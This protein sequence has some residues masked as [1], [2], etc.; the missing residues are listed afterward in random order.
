M[1]QLIKRFLVS[2]V[3][4]VTSICSVVAGPV[5]SA[6]AAASVNARAAIAIDAKSGQVLYSKNADSR[7]A[8]ASMS[9]LLTVAVI[10]HEIANG[11]LKWSTKVKIT[12]A[13][14]KLST[15]SG[16]S[17]VP[18]QSGHRYS[19]KQL[20]K[21]ALIKSGDAATIA[22]SRSRGQSTK[23]FVKEMGATAK[24][25][26]LK[27]YRLYNGVGLSNQDMASFK[28]PN[29][30][31]SAENEMTA[32]D[33]A[34]LA[35]YLIRNHP[36]LLK[37]TKQ[38]TLKWDGQT[39]QNGNELL[40]GNTQAPQKVTVD[41]LKTGTSDKAGQCFAST[42]TYRGHR[43][44]T[45]VMHASG[46]RFTQTKALYEQVFSNWRAHT[47]YQGATVAV[48]HGRQKKVRVRT[49]QKV[50]IWQPVQRTVTSKFVASPHY[51][52]KQGLKAPL[53]QNKRVGKVNFPGLTNVRG[54]VLQIGVYPV[55]DVKRSGLCG[56]LK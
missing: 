24:R 37:I 1:K 25:I 16:Y 17:N 48:S 19:V 4:V 26:G 40:P 41:G 7:M 39:Y 30:S 34:V 31:S 22:L 36:E 46:D 50:T 49:H 2:L 42:G 18:L 43:I 5:G 20:T 15:A 11:Q 14:A 33:V 35:R 3:I 8:V 45:V 27:N 44:I 52:S 21:A 56:W 12:P 47:G 55:E 9:K 28:L 6:H 10:E 53:Y 29:T 13:E 51:Q 38:K 54:K 32:R 23:E